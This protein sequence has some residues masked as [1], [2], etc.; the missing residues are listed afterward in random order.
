MRR[1]LVLGAGHSSSY[2]ITDLL[3]RAVEGGWIVAVADRDPDLAVSRLGGH[4]RGEAVALDARA[5]G[6]LAAH[7][8]GADLVVNLLPPGLQS[9]IARECLRRGRPMI[10]AS[11]ATPEIRP[12]SRP[13]RDVGVMLLMEAGL[14]PGI[15]HMATMSLVDRVHAEGGVVEAFESYG[16]GVPAP[17]SISNP[18]AYVV[19]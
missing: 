17:D 7:L 6:R 8:E 1:I 19:T 10:S 5:E 11:C 13:A 18:L 12:L 15:D 16:S 14:D 9:E 3:R 4:P 2:L